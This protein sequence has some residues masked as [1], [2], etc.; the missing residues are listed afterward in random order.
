[1]IYFIL[2]VLAAG[3]TS[4]IKLDEQK[5]GSGGKI[6]RIERKATEEIPQ[7]LDKKPSTK[8]LTGSEKEQIMLDKLELERKFHKVSMFTS[9]PLSFQKYAPGNVSKSDKSSDEKELASAE[10]ITLERKLLAQGVEPQ[11]EADTKPMNPLDLTKRNISVKISAIKALGEIKEPTVKV[12]LKSVVEQGESAE[13]QAA[14]EALARMG[15]TLGIRILHEGLK[16]EQLESRIEAVNALARVGNR[17]P[18]LQ[19]LLF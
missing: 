8:K 6:F 2:I 17:V 14:A 4:R 13:R 9:P 7:T 16:K 5:V 10:K 19:E 1:M 15:D 12:A 3:D 18:E 11:Q